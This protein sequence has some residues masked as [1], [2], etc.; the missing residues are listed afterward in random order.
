[1]NWSKIFLDIAAKLLCNAP[2]KAINIAEHSRAQKPLCSFLP[3][4]MTLSAYIFIDL[5]DKPCCRLSKK[6]LRRPT[7]FISPIH[8]EDYHITIHLTARNRSTIFIRDD[9]GRVIGNYRENAQV[10]PYF[11]QPSFISLVLSS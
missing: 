7:D 1:M 8:G 6:R 9:D 4:A 5:A 11:C 2:I 10:I 3:E